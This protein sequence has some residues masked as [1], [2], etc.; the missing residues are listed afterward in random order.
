[1]KVDSVGLT[2]LVTS[3]HSVTVTGLHVF[4]ATILHTSSVN[5][6]CDN[7]YGY[8]YCVKSMVY[9]EVLAEGCR[10]EGA[11]LL[12]LLP[13]HLLHHP[14]LHRRALLVASM[15]LFNTGSL[16]K[17][18]LTFLTTSVHTFSS[19][20]LFTFRIT[21]RHFFTSSGAHTL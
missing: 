15:R 4:T 16:L 19:T 18:I 2:F 17:R 13:G 10:L 9:L 1:M 7:I 12:L 3:L 6:T 21:Q 14:P 20:C 5:G 11:L 8:L